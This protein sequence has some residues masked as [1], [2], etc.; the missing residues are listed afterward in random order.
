MDFARTAFYDADE[1]ALWIARRFPQ[2]KTRVAKDEVLHWV[3]FLK[4]GET[5]DD[6]RPVD[7]V[8]YL[9]IDE[10]TAAYNYQTLAFADLG[11]FYKDG[12]N[13]IPYI[14]PDGEVEF[15]VRKDFGIEL[16]PGESLDD[17]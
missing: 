16:P 12:G 4:N 13:R 1:K 2:P 10:E 3:R 7:S 6:G 14:P 5:T 8:N 17:Q 15:D 9:F 11:V